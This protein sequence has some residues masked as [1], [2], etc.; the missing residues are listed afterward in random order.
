MAIRKITECS[1]GKVGRF[2]VENI[3]AACKKEDNRVYNPDKQKEYFDRWYHSQQI[4]GYPSYNWKKRNEQAKRPTKPI[5]TSKG[6][7]D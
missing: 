4:N 7:E 3:C 5:D 2:K 6:T 1:C